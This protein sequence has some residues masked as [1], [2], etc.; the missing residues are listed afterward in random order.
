[1]ENGNR[2]VLHVEADPLP[3]G[4]RNRIMAEVFGV[5]PEIDNEESK[6]V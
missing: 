6:A 4:T 3:A 1:M 2:S 5:F